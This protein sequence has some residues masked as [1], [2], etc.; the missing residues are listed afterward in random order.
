MNDVE[1]TGLY[2]FLHGRSQDRAKL[3]AAL[4]ASIAAK[5][6]ESRETNE[7]GL[8]RPNRIGIIETG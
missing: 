6:R 4:L 8:D 2:P 1:L 7:R 3:D 5:A